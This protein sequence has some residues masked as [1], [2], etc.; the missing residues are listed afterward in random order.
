M[1]APLKGSEL[2]DC[3]RANGTQGID[4][5]AERCGYDDIA[6]YEQALRQAGKELGIDIQGFDS[7]VNTAQESDSDAGVVI[8]PY[9]QNQL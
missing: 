7:L 9:T 2:I 3:S 6:Q 1:A 8:A 4:L 5:A